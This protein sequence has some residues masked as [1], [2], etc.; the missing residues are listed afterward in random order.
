MNR[1]GA[2]VNT[3]LSKIEYLLRPSGWLL[4]AQTTLGTAIERFAVSKTD[5]T[6]TVLDLVVRLRLTEGQTLRG[7]DLGRQLS[8][9]PGYVSRVIDL[10]EEAGLVV[11][12]PDPTDRR[13][14]LI[15]LTDQGEDV[16]DG[17]IPHATAVLKDTIYSTLDET[18]VETLI[19][20]LRKVSDSAHHLL[21]TGFD[22]YPES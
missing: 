11:R 1:S 13:A 12:N 16:F 19:E 21:D 8:K 6:A 20:L 5:Y 14:Q 3:D 15:T 17:F 22:N 9:S 7:V 2:D 10:A 4:E 18:E